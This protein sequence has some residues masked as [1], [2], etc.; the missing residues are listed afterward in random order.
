MDTPRDN[1][2]RFMKL[3]LSRPRMVRD[4]LALLPAEWTAEVDAASLRELPSEFIGAGGEKRIADLCWL[5]E[6]GGGDSAIILI[7]NQSATDRLM[8]ARATTR[9]GLLYESLGPA[10]RRSDGKFPPVLIVVVYTGDRPWRTP[11]DLSGMVHVPASHPLSVPVGPRYA[12]LDLRDPAAQYPEQG[13]RMA[14]LARLV[15]AE[16]YVDAIGLLGEVRGW[17]DFG[18]EDETRLFQC[19]LDWFHATAPE[20]RPRDWNPERERKLEELMAEQSILQRN[21]ERWLEGYRRGAFAEGRTDGRREGLAHE[22][23]LLVQ[24]AARRFGADTG[25]RLEARLRAVE[26]PGY[27]ERVGVLIVECETGEQLLGGIDRSGTNSG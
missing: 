15:F 18:D 21:N 23:A 20:F 13:N 5:A 16:S 7:E 25:R 4:L 24:Q 22:R 27:L 26:D 19:Y 2:D 17:L 3:M 8:P 12:R 9:V 11:D 6:G 10:A 1:Q 14:A